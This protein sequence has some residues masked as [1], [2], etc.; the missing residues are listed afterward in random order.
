MSSVFRPKSNNS[1]STMKKNILVALALLA[2][3]ALAAQ[4]LLVKS[5][6]TAARKAAADFVFVEGGVFTRNIHMGF[7]SLQLG[8]PERTTVQSFHMQRFEVTVEEYQRFANATANPADHYDSTAW[9]KDFPY[10]YNEPMVRNYFSHPKFK[11]YP[12]IGVKWAQAVRYCAWKAHEINQLLIGSPYKVEVRLPTA[13]E[14]EY[15]AYSVG[16]E[17]KNSEVITDRQVFPWPGSF[18]TV[19]KN[20]SLRFNCNSGPLR[21]PQD[22]H[23]LGYPSDGFLYT[24]PVQSFAP[25]GAGLY[26]MAGNVAEWTLDDYVIDTEK[27]NDAL[28]K[29]PLADEDDPEVLKHIVPSFPP[30]RYDGYKIIKG[31]SWNDDPFYMQAAVVK[32]QH[33]TQASSTTGF[34]PVLV[35][36][37]AN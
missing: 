21:M 36:L 5:L 9:T 22:Y 4:P 8:W 15:A 23:L 37:E 19:E 30:D 25:N 17:K 24:A 34:R 11:Q 14:W 1:I 28:S 18:F 10:S 31:G 33:P 7:D 20:G 13:A 32:I 27:I 35:V 16:T 26:Q 6:P 29:A 3:H 2:A 12:V